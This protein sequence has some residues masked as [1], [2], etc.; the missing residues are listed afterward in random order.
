MELS[1]SFLRIMLF[2]PLAMFLIFAMLSVYFCCFKKASH[3]RTGVLTF[4]FRN[5]KFLM[6]A[7]ITIID[8]FI[9][10]FSGAIHLNKLL[11][12]EEMRTGFQ[13]LGSS[14]MATIKS[15]GG[16][17]DFTSYITGADA[18]FS[19]AVN[20]G[21]KL[22]GAFSVYAL[23]IALFAP[24]TSVAFVVNV[25]TTLLPKLKLFINLRPRKYYFSELNEGSL[26]L[27][28]SVSA[29]F[30]GIRPLIVFTD[31]HMASGDERVNELMLEAR[32]MGACCIRDDITHLPKSIV[33][34][35]K[36]IFLIDKNEAEN[37]HKLAELAGGRWVDYLRKAE[38]Y[39]FCADG[40]YDNVRDG[41]LGTVAAKYNC[42]KNDE[43]MPAIIPVYV[44]RNLASR[45]L[46]DVPAYEG[47]VHKIKNGID[48]P[49][50]FTIFG[51]GKIGTEMFLSAYR[52]CQMLGVKLHITVVSD[53][54]EEDF[55]GRIDYINPDIMN[56]AVVAHP[57]LAV[58]NN[59]ETNAPYF[60]F[61]YTR[62][63]I[64]GTN[65]NTLLDSPVAGSSAKIRDSHY[66]VVALGSDSCNIAIAEKLR[67]HIG[68]YHIGRQNEKT[69][70]AYAVYDNEL[71]EMFNKNS[72]RG[73]FCNSVSDIFMHA[74]GNLA[75]EYSVSNILMRDNMSL[76]AEIQHRYN[77]SGK[78]VHAE[79]DRKRKRR[80]ID[81]LLQDEYGFTSDLA[82]TM[83]IKYK[84]FSAGLI[85]FSVFDC[86]GASEYNRKY[87]EALAKYASADFV[88]DKNERLAMFHRLA[89]LEHRR[90]C[91]DLRT[92]GFRNCGECV[93]FGKTSSHKNP[94]LKLHSC[95]VEC[96]MLGIRGAEYDDRCFLLNDIQTEMVCT[97]NYDMLDLVTYEARITNPSRENFKKYDYIEHESLL[98]YLRNTVAD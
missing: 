3:G 9:L 90:W 4:W 21:E 79:L 41:V 69:V 84:L 27:A 73:S 50:Y 83:H 33:A 29:S 22:A 44:Y 1:I 45:L 81:K 51:T 26:A 87:N 82:R 89:W 14:I 60:S 18:V 97:E 88:E 15:F 95:L 86:D 35:D 11:P 70:I 10:T 96:D 24:V 66:F 77:E 67:Q 85:D 38:I 25:L 94:D 72:H 28:K 19:A 20:P 65:M 31:V 23:V 61:S 91:A 7:V 93:I 36:K 12:A 59:G 6:F 76:M 58:N 98:T 75:E 54:A 2:L 34:A 55:R 5:K 32:T 68:E 53:E 48:V 64:T 78:A 74:F 46:Y 71:C 13:L 57:I 30:S 16:M 39:L 43:K 80:V 37:V 40:V 17:D 56:T 49:L 62:C 63:N 92:R 42:E 47:I 8:L 52:T